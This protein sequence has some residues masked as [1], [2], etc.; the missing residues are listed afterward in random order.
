MANGG[1]DPRRKRRR[2]RKV[3]LWDEDDPKVPASDATNVAKA[4]QKRGQK[5]GQASREAGGSKRTG[6]KRRRDRQP[7]A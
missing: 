7:R 3:I 5:T 4:G 2:W 6:K 1:N